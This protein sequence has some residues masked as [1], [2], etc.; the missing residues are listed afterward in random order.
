MPEERETSLRR[1]IDIPFVISFSSCYLGASRHRGSFLIG[2]GGSSRAEPFLHEEPIPR[3][4]AIPFGQVG[5][6][7]GML[8][9]PRIERIMA[10]KREARIEAIELNC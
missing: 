4:A 5:R 8:D 9:G 3:N 6:E 7:I 1:P 2:P 10:R